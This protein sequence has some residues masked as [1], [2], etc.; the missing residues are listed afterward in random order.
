MIE[1]SYES[2]ASFGVLV[3]HNYQYTIYSML[4]FIDIDLCSEPLI[5]LTVTHLLHFLM[6]DQ[7]VI[8]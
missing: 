7:S 1:R 3:Y 6:N 8:P 5:Y 4:Y 2:A